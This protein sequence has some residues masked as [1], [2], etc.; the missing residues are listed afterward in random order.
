[1]PERTVILLVE[2]DPLARL[3]ETE[4]LEKK[5]YDVIPVSTG[6][7]AIAA[8]RATP[9]IALILM[10]RESEEKMDGGEAAEA[11][12]KEYDIPIVFISGHTEGDVADKTGRITSYG[13]VVR[14]SGIAVLDASIK[15][16]LKLH[17][18]RRDLAENKKALRES[19]QDLHRALELLE[20][21]TTGANV[22]IVAVDRDLRLTYFNQGHRE[23]SKRL[24]GKEI[25]I[26][27]S[28]LDVLADLPDQRKTA[29]DLWERTLK[30]ET[31]D[32]TLMVGDPGR[33]CR[34]YATRHTPILDLEG[35]VVGAGAVSSDVTDFD[36]VKA[37]HTIRLSEAALRAVIDNSP[38]PIFLKDRNGRLLLANPATL[39]AIG[40]P[41]EEVIG[42]TDGEF[43]DDP[44]IGRVIMETDRRIMD[45]NQTE[46]L[47]ET[48]R[49]GRDERIYL[50]TKA[51]YHD[52]AG[53]VLG[54]IGIARDITERKRAEEALRESEQKLG[55]LIEH[56]P[57]SI[58]MFDRTMRY[59]AVSRRWL[60]DYRLGDQ[61]I[62]GRKP[63]LRYS[64]ISLNSGR[65]CT[66]GA[67]LGAIEKCEEDPFPRLDGRVDWVRWEI[68]PWHEQNGDVGG[69]IICTENITERKAAE[70]EKELSVRFLRIINEG[71]TRTDLIHGAVTFFQEQSGCAAVGIRLHD[72]DDYPYFEVHGFPEQFVLLESSLCMRDE[73]GRPV[74]DRLRQSHSGVHVRQ[75]NSGEV[76]SLKALLYQAGKFLD[77]Q[78]D[79]ASC[80]HHQRGPT[81]PNAQPVQRRRVRI[82]S[83]YPAGGRGQTSGP[84]PIERPP[85]G[86]LH[87]GTDQPLR[88]AIGLPGGGTGEG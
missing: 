84:P 1:M 9:G 82:G 88:E 58:A 19:G 8:V 47:E 34:W 42:K 27:M 46:V 28:L 55:L 20:A 26:G 29:L 52:A 72:K 21:V 79:E 83:P 61:S 45:S 56:A 87:S 54:L 10:A 22:Q 80:H 57:A 6:D 48:I 73:Q 75:R 7:A 66:K 17:K 33:Y 16:A 40:K 51:P 85:E 13:Y 39:A 30:G 18:A 78:Y 43:Y 65:Q 62:I 2:K 38:D 76:R 60:A 41:A 12:L 59:M 63:L 35:N 3:N 44:K 5:G 71:G 32:Q 70:E 15:T 68:L 77:K 36:F 25:E 81:G 24:T 31:I 50:S 4:M 74:R 53:Q 86:P 23:E 14:G 69:I 49:G 37:Q 67:S 11:I 64:P